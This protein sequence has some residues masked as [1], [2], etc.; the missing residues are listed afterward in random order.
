MGRVERGWYRTRR[1]PIPVPALCRDAGKRKGSGALGGFIGFV[2]RSRSAAAGDV[3]TFGSGESCEALVQ[4]GGATMMRYVHLCPRC[5]CSHL[6]ICMAVPASWFLASIRVLPFEGVSDDPE[7]R[8]QEGTEIRL[9]RALLVRPHRAARSRRP[10]PQKGTAWCLSC[11]VGVG[12]SAGM[13]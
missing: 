8:E 11:R 2:V 10:I 12:R 3:Q 6:I 4:G 9:W 13:D 1:F 7:T 5:A